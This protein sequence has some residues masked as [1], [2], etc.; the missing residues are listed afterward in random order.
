ML[1]TQGQMLKGKQEKFNPE[2]NGW[3]VDGNF[4]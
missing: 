1:N 3:D 4:L 2:R